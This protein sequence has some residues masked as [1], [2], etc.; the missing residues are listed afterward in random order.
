MMN[1]FNRAMILFSISYCQ[2]EPAQS[3][4]EDAPS[5]DEP[6]AHCITHL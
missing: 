2:S 4:I 6:N 5:N 1:C 3:A